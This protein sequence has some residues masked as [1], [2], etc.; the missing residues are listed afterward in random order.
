M[1]DHPD[2]TPPPETLA[3]LV[4]RVT[5]QNP[6]TGF[7]ILRVTARGH[8][9][10]VTVLG[11]APELNPG[12]WVEAAGRWEQDPRHGKQFRAAEL[13]LSRP[14]TLEGIQRYL[15]SGLIPGI[16]PHYA[17]KL[18]ATF[19]AEVFDVMENRSAR[20]LE[21]EGIGPTRREQIRA[22][23]QEQKRIR[24]IMAFLFSHGVSTARAFRIYKAYGEGAI[25]KVRLDPY[26][27]ARDI[28][29][30]GFKTADQIAQR[31]GIASDSDLRARA[32]VEY[33]LLERTKEG[34]CTCLRPPLVEQT[35][36]ALGIPDGIVETAVDHGLREKRLVQREGPEG[37][38]VY[39]AALDAAETEVARRIAR[40]TEG[41]AP[42]A[43]VDA[44]R[45][46]VWV[47]QR[48]GFQLDGAQRDAVR[49]ALRSKTLVI[50][51]G[52]GV[53][54]TT[55]L[56]AI[57]EIYR[58][59]KMRVHLCAPTG[60]AAKRLSEST[61][62]PAQTIH[63]LLKFDPAGGGFLHGLDRPL[64]GDV[65][66]V[67]ESSMVDLLL[68]Q[69]LV[70][71]IPPSAA[72]VLV[73]D[74]DQLP[75]VG[76]GTVLQDL[77]ASGCI[78]VCR[79]THVFRQ[80]ARSRIVT[81][82]HRINQGEMPLFPEIREGEVPEDFF[83]MEA[84]DPQKAVASILRL[85]RKA[86]PERFHLH[87]L[88]DIQVLTPMQR[89]ELGARNLN[90][91]LQQELNPSAPF[92][93]RF[94]VQ[95]REGDKVMQL[96]NDYD[97]DVF[98]G[99]IG[100]ILRIREESRE[101]EVSFDGRSVSYRAHELDELGLSYAVTIHKSQGSEYP[102]VIV[103]IHTQHFTMLRRNLLYTAVTRGKQLVVLVGTRKA[104]AI[105]VRTEDARRRQTTLRERVL[106]AFGRPSRPGP[107]T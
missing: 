90:A 68:A 60:R 63:R 15:G 92:L 5:F 57:V 29:G 25:D 26:C 77:I 56:R 19:G 65:F 88:D 79:L 54:K 13:K 76:P 74:A 43:G 64:E 83:F 2:A 62:V 91:V 89:G 86:V 53:G 36:T 104:L 8:R 98:N 50:T 18:V 61:R 35:A 97:K 52:P 47:E 27:L 42:L 49:E 31:L 16:G 38:R 17:E 30:I 103:P 6:E 23:W 28:T 32:G 100:R 55:I 82:A 58:A 3:G 39:L 66:I 102:C 10:I 71:A 73:G 70:R 11:V 78:P 14:D 81:N 85:V 7:C 4:E 46:L 84:D 80:A 75:S 12:E 51:G 21:V 9:E 48:V 94:G 40:L 87:P 44:D 22:S 37:S 34:H 107:G 93:E 45:A 33:L 105:A 41:S 67:D 101:V 96:E 99:D 24:D 69:S 59:K 95:Y 20:L 106:E 72:L 1:P